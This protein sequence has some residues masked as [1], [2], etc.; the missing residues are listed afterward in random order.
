MLFVT[1]EV[2]ITDL[3]QLQHKDILT[4]EALS[5]ITG[6][7]RTFNPVRLKLLEARNMRQHELDHG[8]LPTF[9]PETSGV[10]H[11][12]WQVAPAPADLQK[13]WVEIT[14]PVDR[15]MMINALNSEAD[16]FMADFEDSLAPTWENILQGQINLRDAVRGT[17]EFRNADGKSYTLNGNT[18][19]LLVRPRG[20]HLD[21]ER[22]L[23]GGTP[24]S[25]SLFDFGL[26]FFHNVQELISRG[27]GPYFY[28][29]K[30]ESHREARVWND[31]FN[32]AQDLLG[33]P[34]GTI[35]AT[36]R[37]AAELSPREWEVIACT[38]RG[39][40]N[41]EIAESL[42]VSA[43]TIRFHLKSI[44][45]KIHVSNRTEAAAWY[46]AHKGG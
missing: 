4:A 38:A 26:Y 30:L 39:L 8:V 16:M 22:V 45:A 32:M 23:V 20:W 43:N 13:R 31:V 6:L 33:T 36:G 14:G 12:E 17:I 19:T 21:E 2:K 29:P 35:K 18:A 27:S 41:P 34:R 37:A 9:L 11:S 40:T 28:L 1:D 15:K 42:G 7:Q 5:F 10:R 3:P 24:V 44:F 25:A 46:F